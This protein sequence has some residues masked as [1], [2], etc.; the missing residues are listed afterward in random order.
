MSTLRMTFGTSRCHRHAW[1]VGQTG[2]NSCTHCRLAGNH[3]RVPELPCSI[4]LFE[5]DLGFRLF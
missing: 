4:F 2:T 1:Q 3:Q 5:V